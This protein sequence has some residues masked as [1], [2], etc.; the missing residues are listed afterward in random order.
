MKSI[1]TA[2]LI[3]T[4]AMLCLA[5]VTSVTSARA[6]QA[7]SEDAE[8]DVGEQPSSEVTAWNTFASKLVA[9]NLPPGPQTYTLAVAHIAIHDALNAIDPRYDPYEF[10][11]SAPGASVAAAVAAAAHDT[12]VKLVPQAAA[13]VDAAYDAAL[14]SVQE[15]AAKDA[16]VATGQAAAAAILARR[17]FDDLLAA[18]TK[19]YTPGPANPG[20]YQPTP[21]LNFVL[22]A[23]WSELPP[24][25][26]NSAS[27]FRSPAPASV[28]SFKYTID[29]NEVK[30]VGSASSTTR[31][32][33]QTETAL[34]W[35]DAATK[36]WNF[37]A[38]KGLADL[39]ANE[40]RAARTLAVLNISLADA[41][42]ATFDTKFHYNYWRPITAIRAGDHDGNSATQG[43]PTWEPLCVTLPFPEYASTH[44]A[45]AAAAAGTLALELGDRHTFTVTSPNG[46]SRTYNRFS[47]AAYEEGISRIYC[48]IH[49]R[50]AMNTGFVQGSL[51]AH[52][53]DKNL[54]QPLDDRRPPGSLA[55]DRPGGSETIIVDFNRLDNSRFINAPGQSGDPGSR[56]YDDLLKRWQRVEY[57]PM[58]FGRKWV[59]SPPHERLVAEP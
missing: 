43:D 34:F 51:I 25:A 42:I 49:F 12:L 48:G 21:P 35:Y 50:T 37:A 20:V 14:A 28:K 16:G 39:S 44:A 6:S 9:A 32:A 11:G 56:H 30:T 47:A 55:S 15:G 10:A 53:V 22:L 19:P 46:A 4:L 24:F 52:Y 18:I 7:Q 57:L 17:S 31:T 58:R 33:E 41:G 40:W 5:A 23:G 1:R 38:Q 27:Q 8:R 54:L 45:T 3:I 29:Y 26:L 36:E 13:A 2:K 59:D